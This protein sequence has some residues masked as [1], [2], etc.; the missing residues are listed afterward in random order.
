MALGVKGEEA[1]KDLVAE[2]GGPEQAAL[3]GVVVFVRVLEEHGSACAARS[4]QP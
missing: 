1:A 4:C 2:V 3:I